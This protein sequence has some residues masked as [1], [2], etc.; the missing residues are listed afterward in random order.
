[1][2]AY[3]SRGEGVFSASVLATTLEGAP[4]QAPKNV[5]MNVL[6]STAVAVTFQQ[7]DE[8]FINGVNLG[9]KVSFGVLLAHRLFV[10]VREAKRCV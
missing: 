5:Q 6:N 8:Q 10:L 1:M 4:T 3:N 9:Y 7:P 2:A